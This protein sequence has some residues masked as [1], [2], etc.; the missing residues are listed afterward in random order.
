[1]YSNNWTECKY[2]NVTPSSMLSHAK[3]MASRYIYHYIIYIYLVCLYCLDDGTLRKCIIQEPSHDKRS[4]TKKSAVSISGQAVL[5]PTN[6]VNDRILLET[7]VPPTQETDSCRQAK[8]WS[9][10]RSDFNSNSKTPSVIS[11]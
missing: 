5:S 10:V 3:F 2:T 6:T 7:N 4:I 11:R 9:T 8:L 1:M